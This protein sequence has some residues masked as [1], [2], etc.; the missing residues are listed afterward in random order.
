MWVVFDHAALEIV[1]MFHDKVTAESWAKK[2]HG[3]VQVYFDSFA[4]FF[5]MVPVTE[6]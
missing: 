2:Y 4:V 5:K 6:G 1:A 3:T